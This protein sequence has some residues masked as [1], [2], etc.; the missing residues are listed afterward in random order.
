MLP[1]TVAAQPRPWLQRRRWRGAEG[2][3]GCRAQPGP[4][5]DPPPGQERRPWSWEP[6]PGRRPALEEL[7]A[8]LPDGHRIE[9]TGTAP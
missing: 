4:R 1:A 3:G 7:P 8:G 9:R 2:P 5:R 6:V